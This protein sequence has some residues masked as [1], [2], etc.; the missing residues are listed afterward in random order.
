MYV[1]DGLTLTRLCRL[2]LWRGWCR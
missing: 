2:D 1:E